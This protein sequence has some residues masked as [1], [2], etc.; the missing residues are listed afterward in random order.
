MT[1]YDFIAYLRPYAWT[2]TSYP[3]NHQHCTISGSAGNRDIP[4]NSPHTHPQQADACLEIH[5]LTI[6][7]SRLHLPVR[8]CPGQPPLPDLQTQA[9]R[10]WSLPRL[11]APKPISHY[12]IAWWLLKFLM[13]PNDQKVMLYHKIN[14]FA[15]LQAWNQLFP[16]GFQ[17]FS[18][19]L[20]QWLL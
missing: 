14:I 11:R 13:L 16:C 5:L 19:K 2:V 7:S 20:T 15:C 1:G 6:A 4:F 9:P 17:T 10:L 12:L 18:M 3:I 8:P